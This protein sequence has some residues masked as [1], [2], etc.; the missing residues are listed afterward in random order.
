MKETQTVN[1]PPSPV[2]F[3]KHLSWETAEQRKWSV[4]VSWQSTENSKIQ[5]HWLSLVRCLLMTANPTIA[6]SH[7]AAFI[8]LFPI[9][10]YLKVLV[11]IGH[12]IYKIIDTFLCY[13]FIEPRALCVQL[14]GYE[15]IHF[16]SIVTAFL[17]LVHDH[18]SIKLIWMNLVTF[19]SV[20]F[21][22]ENY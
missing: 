10:E 12:S 9:S 21:V 8:I 4:W 11:L 5:K 2:H 19:S 3:Q 17:I 22:I 14:T 6:F 7:T 16:Y 1:P 18:N 15:H 20:C 13:F